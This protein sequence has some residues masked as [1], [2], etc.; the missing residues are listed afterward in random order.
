M[1]RLV[2][3]LVS[4]TTTNTLHLQD[5][6]VKRYASANKLCMV[7]RWIQVGG[8]WLVGELVAGCVILSSPTPPNTNICL[9]SDVR[10]RTQP[11]MGGGCVQFGGCG[12]VGEWV[13]GCIGW[14]VNWLFP[15]TTPAPKPCITIGG[16]VGSGRG[17][18]IKIVNYIV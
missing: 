5:L 13:A 3:G 14:C 10:R 18:V 9:L 6:F 2:R 4:P 17:S 11:C 12:L 7:G 8:G 16:C 1:R 15:P